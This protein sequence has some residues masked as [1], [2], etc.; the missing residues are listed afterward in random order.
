MPIFSPFRAALIMSVIGVFLVGLTGRVAYLQTYGREQ[1]I[2]RAERQ[3]H[4][5]E[6]LF[7]RR[8]SI[9]DTTGLLMGQTADHLTS[10][11]FASNP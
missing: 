10:Y 7:A 4:Q 8:G 5:S 3:Q 1:T 11:R 2:R 9:F 6:T